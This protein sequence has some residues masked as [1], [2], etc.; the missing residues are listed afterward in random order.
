VS[1]EPVV[2]GEFEDAALAKI[3]A[4]EGLGVTAVPTV[5]AAEAI[6]R[7]GFVSLGK[8]DQCQIQLYLI[9]AE[10]RIEHPA[11]ALLAREAEAVSARPVRR[12][13]GDSKRAPDRAPSVRKAKTKADHQKKNPALPR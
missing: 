10:R 13:S 9:S 3:V 4:T 5:V 1:I 6:E 2:V 12:F 11:V 7:Y 8:T